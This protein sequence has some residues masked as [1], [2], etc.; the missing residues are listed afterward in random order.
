MLGAIDQAIFEKL[1]DY[2]EGQSPWWL[3]TVLSTYGSA[4]RPVGSHFL[5]DGHFRLGSISGG[6]LE[7]AFV[8]HLPQRPSMPYLSLFDYKADLLQGAPELP[9]GGQIQLLIE[10]LTT[11]R[12]IQAVLTLFDA[13]Q[14]PSQVRRIFDLQHQSTNLAF[15]SFELHQTEITQV[16]YPIQQQ[17]L[18]LGASA[19]SAET[20]LLAER[21]GYMVQVCDIRSHFI[22]NWSSHIQLEIRPSDDFVEAYCHGQTGVLALAHDPRVDD[23]GLASALQMNPFFIGALGSTQTHQARV[24]RL[25]R[26]YD[27]NAATLARVHAPIG[28]NIG[29]KTPAAIAVAIMAQIIGYRQQSL[30]YEQATV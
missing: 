11:D 29:S 8:N 5:T 25:S 30:V 27:F 19:V 20:A 3:C 17:L 4:P 12:H 10:C 23:L 16:L 24:D 21:C 7:D 13:L 26:C 18:L 2:R 9:C 1:K 14:Q 28:L 6:C 15:E 22:A